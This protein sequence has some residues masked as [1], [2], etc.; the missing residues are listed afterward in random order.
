MHKQDAPPAWRPA[1]A[2]IIGWLMIATATTLTV[3]LMP[4]PAML[5]VAGLLALSHAGAALV[6]AQLA[7][8]GTGL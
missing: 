8:R 5:L 7:A 3:L 4:W 1:W 6:R 2:G